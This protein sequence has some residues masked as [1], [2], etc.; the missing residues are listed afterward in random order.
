VYLNIF[1]NNSNLF[2]G[3]FPDAWVSLWS[4][5]WVR[6]WLVG[7]TPNLYSTGLVFAPGETS[8]LLHNLTE[9]AGMLAGALPFESIVQ[10]YN[11][12]VFLMMSLN[13]ISALALFRLLR[14]PWIVAVLLSLLFA[15]HPYIL[16]HLAGGHL[17]LLVQFPICISLIGLILILRDGALM[18]GMFCLACS[19]AFAAYTDW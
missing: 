13:Y 19:I 9:S 7:L 1:L 15:F 12:T 2:P 5:W 3:A 8:L 11:A 18:N 10:S 17:I 14:S 6:Q 16:S 4:I